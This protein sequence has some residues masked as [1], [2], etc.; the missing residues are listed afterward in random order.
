MSLFYVFILMLVNRRYFRPKSYQSPT[1][2]AFFTIMKKKM[3]GLLYS[4]FKN[5]SYFKVSV[6]IS[7][8]IKNGHIPDN[9]DDYTQRN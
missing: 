7:S 5:F 6:E 9:T 3:A 8:P 2:V 1:I 4:S